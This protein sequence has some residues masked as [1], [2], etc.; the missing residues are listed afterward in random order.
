[1][2]WATLYDNVSLPLRIQGRPRTDARHRI[3]PT[4]ASWRS[5]G[6]P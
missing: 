4:L 1:M 3:E 6:A 5:D 2:P